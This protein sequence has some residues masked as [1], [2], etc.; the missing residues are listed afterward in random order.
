MTDKSMEIL[1]HFVPNHDGW[2]LAVKQSFDRGSL[3]TSRWPVVIVPGYGM[4]AFIFGYHPEGRSMEEYL[5][6]AGFEVW[7]VNLRTQ[8]E[9][10][11]DGGSLEYG[12]KEL[13]LVDLPAVIDYI[14]ENTMSETKKAAVIGCSLGGTIVYAY[15]GIHGSDKLGAIITL[16]APL[17]W[18]AIH[19][20]LGF[21]FGS[22]AVSGWL[23]ISNTRTLARLFLPL[24][25]KVPW[26]L[27][28][29]IHPEITD[30]SR[31]DILC[32]TV[33][34]PNRTLNREIS[35]WIRNKDL[36]IDGRNVTECFKGV[37]SPLFCM[38][39]NADGIVPPET[40]L[41]ALELSPA[42]IRKTIT[43]GDEDAKL[44]HA[45][46]YISRHAQEMVFKPIVEWFLEL[47]DS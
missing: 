25:A 36:I 37:E 9:S 38:L 13:S 16:G 28:I 23:K 19:P 18:E 11:C 6:D 33:E 20:V 46:M 27:S 32:R 41:S 8:G 14:I 22:P 2:R 47:Q 4:N 43:V 31:S 29:Y 3:D 44:A 26:L 24:L 40:A 42:R 12:M 7:S 15:A 30:V 39:A 21:A 45:D 34:D 1:N 17:R 5:V 10:I 35:T